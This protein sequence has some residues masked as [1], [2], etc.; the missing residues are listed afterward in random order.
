[1]LVVVIVQVCDQ[2]VRP[3]EQRD[4]AAHTERAH[5]RERAQ[6]EDEQGDVAC[7]C[8]LNRFGVDRTAECCDSRRCGGPD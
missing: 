7:R 1:V 3:V 2:A 5:N 6:A 8:E 4:E